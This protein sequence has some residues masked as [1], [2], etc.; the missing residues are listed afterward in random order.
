MILASQ[1]PR[2]RE[3]LRMISAEFEII[4]AHGEENIPAGTPADT[5]V[6]LLAKQKAHEIFAEHKG[7]LI[8]AADTVVAVD[9]KILGKPADG[10]NAREML[11]QLSGRTHSV[12]TGVCIIAENGGEKTFCEETKVEFYPLTDAEISDYIATGEPLDKAGAYGIQEKGA[13][14]VKRIDGDFFNVVGLPVARVYREL[15]LMQV[16]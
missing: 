8:I 7:E 10:E 13:L 9:G 5:A 4:P 1:S 6:M 16:N 15:K 12:F 3:L 14:L 2:R 11:K